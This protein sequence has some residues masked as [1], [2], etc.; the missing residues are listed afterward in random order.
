M[1]HGF[2]SC[3]FLPL[4]YSFYLCSTHA[5][6]ACFG[7]ILRQSI[8]TIYRA[9]LSGCSSALHLFLL[10]LREAEYVESLWNAYF[11]TEFQNFLLGLKLYYS[12][13]SW[14]L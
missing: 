9:I 13:T 4:I 14:V 1:F 8:T 5:L 7:Y 2:R 10:R 11:S 3:N 12:I 6:A